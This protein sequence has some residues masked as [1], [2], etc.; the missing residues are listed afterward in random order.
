MTDTNRSAVADAGQ[1]EEATLR[2]ARWTC[3][4]GSNA[5]SR[6]AVVLEGGEHR[7]QA[8]AEGNGPVSALFRAVDIALHDVLGGHPRLVAFDVHAVAEGA[9]AEGR[10]VVRLAPPEAAGGERAQGEYEGVSQR[11]NIIA[12]SVEA[13]IDAINKLLAED[14]WAGATDEAGNW[15]AAPNDSGPRSQFDPSAGKLENNSWF[16]R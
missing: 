13:Y 4:S 8:S 10:V 6:G 2:L 11:V 3:N 12:A 7:W 1:A 16:E 9:E 14:H 15:R 5:Q